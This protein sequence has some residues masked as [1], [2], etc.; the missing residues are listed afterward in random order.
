MIQCIHALC[1]I[2]ITNVGFLYKLY[3]HVLLTFVF[4]IC[5]H[6]CKLWG[7]VCQNIDDKNTQVLVVFTKH[8]R[9]FGKQLRVFSKGLGV[10]TKQLRVFSK[11]LRVFT[12]QLRV[13]SK[14]LRV[15]TKQLRVF[16]KRL[17]VFSK[18][19]RV[20]GKG[21]IHIALC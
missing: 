13:F 19:L 21:P 4:V 2:V 11:G 8:L 1:I 5:I 15:F 6:V 18:Q 7:A 20:F 16:S 14:G 10:F 12:K 17:R 3:M 9:V